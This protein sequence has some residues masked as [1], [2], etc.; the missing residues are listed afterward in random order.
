MLKWEVFINDNVLASLAVSTDVR[1]AFAAACV[2]VEVKLE[3]KH[4]YFLLLRN[5]AVSN[6]LLAVIIYALSFF[7]VLISAWCELVA[8]GYPSFNS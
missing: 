1:E 2:V 7:Y 4:I 3:V 6:E 8:M 5:V